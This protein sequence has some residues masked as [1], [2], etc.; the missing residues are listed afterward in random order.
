M[1][2]HTVLA[3]AALAGAVMLVVGSSSRVAAIVAVIAAAVDVAI[4]LGVIHLGVSGVSLALVIGFALAVPGVL[5]W[6][7]VASKSAVSAATVVA[8][9][10]ALKVVLALGIRV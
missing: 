6:L 10:G 4:R 8:L 7:R 9:V 5:T 3:L 2:V 1:N